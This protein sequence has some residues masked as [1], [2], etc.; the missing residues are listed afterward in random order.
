MRKHF[1]KIGAVFVL[2][3]FAVSVSAYPTMNYY[4]ITTTDSSFELD[5]YNNT[6]TIGNIYAGNITIS[7]DLNVTG[8]QYIDGITVMSAS[9]FLVSPTDTGASIRFNITTG[10][11]VY[12]AGT[13][14][15]DG[16]MNIAD[17]LN[18]NFIGD[19]RVNVT[20]ILNVEGEAVITENVTAYNVWTPVYLFT[21]SNSSQAVN[22]AGTYENVSF[23]ESASFN[24]SVTH[25]HGGTDNHSFFITA[26]GVYRINYR[27]TFQS[28]AIEVAYTTAILTVN[29]VEIEGSATSKTTYRQHNT[30]SLSNTVIVAL[31][32]SDNIS[33]QFTSSSTNVHLFSNGMYTTHP[34]SATIAINRIG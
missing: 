26:D 16:N 10:G 28:S 3:F 6:A 14:T 12:M 18:V 4:G 32:S 20:G 21:H 22:G 25:N 15:N 33:I 1:K 5:I 9:G 24:Q 23:N 19:D 30:T 17:I 13:F 29:D 8:N 27:I 2:L 11:N 31:T 34:D 7:G